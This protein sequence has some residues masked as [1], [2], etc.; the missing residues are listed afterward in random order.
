M[1]KKY[2]HELTNKSNTEHEASEKEGNNSGVRLKF[3]FV[4][5]RFWDLKRI[6]HKADR[7]CK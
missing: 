5:I 6:R 1:N 3:K 4:T 2:K 7:S